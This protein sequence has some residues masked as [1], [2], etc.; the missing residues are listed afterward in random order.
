M[1]TGKP[2]GP[3]LNQWSNGMETIIAF[4]EHFGATGW[5]SVWVPMVYW[6]MA[7][8]PAWLLMNRIGSRLHPAYHHA[9]RLAVLSTLPIGILL[10]NI[11]PLF[12]SMPQDIIPFMGVLNGAVS[13]QSLP[14]IMVVGVPERADEGLF[15]SISDVTIPV[16]VGL[17]QAL[18]LTVAIGLLIRHGWHHVRLVL[19]RRY[20]LQPATARIM[21]TAAP[22]LKNA[23]L[24]PSRVLLAVSMDAQVPFTFGWLKPVIVLPNREFKTEK[25]RSLLAHEIMHVRH[26]DYLIEWMVQVLRAVCWFHPLVQV[27]ARDVHRYREMLC[28]AE[29]ISGMIAD[30]RSY[31]SLLLEFTGNNRQPELSVMISMATTKSRLKERITAMPTYPKS[32]EKLIY[33]R[34]M[35]FWTALSVMVVLMFTMALTA[36]TS[37]NTAQDVAAA[38]ISAPYSPSFNLT[39]AAVDSVYRVAETMPEPIGG[40]AAIYN[41]IR[42]PEAARA[43]SIEGQVVIQFVVN[44][45]GEVISPQVVRGVRPD[46]DQAALQALDGIRFFPGIQ[47]GAPV[48]VQFMLP[49]VFRLQPGP[50]PPPPP[51][52]YTPPPRNLDQPASH[53]GEDVFIVVEQMPS[54]IGGLESIYNN[55]R[56]P[57]AAREAGVE[58]RV[59]VQFLVDKEGNV[60]DPFILRGIGYGAD[61][62]ALEAVKDAKFTPGVQRGV[63]VN[64]V[65]QLPIVFRLAEE[66][67][68]ER[69]GRE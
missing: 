9:I 47:N 30:P 58:G 13:V 62:I 38:A 60:V 36:P 17:A 54:P 64:V 41:N 66:E 1:K 56:Y 5:K 48:K 57:D 46:L 51:P 59:V 3:L 45:R 63:P 43:D 42:Y 33:T 35:S 67:V 69:D 6:S 27:Y 2:S 8:L 39:P 20:G 65:L 68:Q 16:W 37:G 28:D 34:K 25:L 18:L 23:G 11:V 44:E 14:E 24:N 52:L 40:M 22:L 12:I 7:A 10:A 32:P 53:N 29:V 31:A 19:L 50:P 49:I 26:N 15:R 61:E 21:E 55:I 4:L